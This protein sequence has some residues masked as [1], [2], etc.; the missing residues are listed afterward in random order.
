MLDECAAIIHRFSDTVIVVDHLGLL[1][2]MRPPV[3]VDV[4]ANF[5]NCSRWRSIRMFG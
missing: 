1:Q 3:P 2:P 4:W 5:R